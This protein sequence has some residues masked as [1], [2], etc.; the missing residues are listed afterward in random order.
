MADSGWAKKAMWWAEGIRFGADLSIWPSL[1]DL[2][3][4]SLRIEWQGC[5]L[6][7]QPCWE[8]VLPVDVAAFAVCLLH[9][10]HW[11]QSEKE[12]STIFNSPII[13]HNCARSAF[14]NSF[15]SKSMPRSRQNQHLWPACTEY[16]YIYYICSIHVSCI[17]CCLVQPKS[18]QTTSL[19]QE[20]QSMAQA[21]GRRL[22][23]KI[24][25]GAEVRSSDRD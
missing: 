3:S 19:V 2:F 20:I 15:K 10:R 13:V 14:F 22:V 5:Q 11:S 16:L 17:T 25:E 7:L 8:A 23:S 6:L 24:S 1:F 18:L 12:S 21:L 9:Q 4:F